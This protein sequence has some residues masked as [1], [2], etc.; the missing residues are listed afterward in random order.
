M[1]KVQ[2][3]IFDMDGI[4]ADSEPC[5]S[6][7]D[8]A[9][10][11]AY[12][13]KY[14]DDL[15]PHVLGKGFPIAVGFYKEH[16]GIEADLEEMIARR[17][18]IADEFYTQQIPLFDSAPKVLET[19]SAQLP[20]GLATSSIATLALP[21]L[22]RHNIAQ[23]FTEIT[24]GDEVENGKPHPDIYLKTA[25]K[26]GI[27]PQNCWVV[28]DALSGVQAGRSAGMK[29]VAIPDSRFMDAELYRDRA[30]HILQS[31]EELPEFI[32]SLPR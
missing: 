8:T 1:M 12:N 9:L 25:E 32:L 27:S 26:L 13:I 5:W 20:L 15:K 18:A 29:V 31:L 10:L 14:S 4:L 28:E 22:K 11:K 19:L 21:F 17:R 6:E 30:D 24:T 3:V 2:S 23:Y 16:F 7:I